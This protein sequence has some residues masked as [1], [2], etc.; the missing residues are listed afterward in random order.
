MNLTD[1]DE[2]DN[3][4]ISQSREKLNESCDKDEPRDESSEKFGTCDVIASELSSLA[5]NFNLTSS[6]KSPASPKTNQGQSRPIIQVQSETHEAVTEDIHV[7]QSPIVS[8]EPSQSSETDRLLPLS[9]KS[10]IDMILNSDFDQLD[11]I[12]IGKS[13]RNLGLINYKL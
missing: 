5:Q 2:L 10:R 11:R 12:E 6:P 7:E 13:G 4:I 1:L 8:P 9:P 3:L